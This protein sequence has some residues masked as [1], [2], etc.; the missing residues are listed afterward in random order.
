MD[1][2]QLLILHCWQYPFLYSDG[3]CRG[4]VTD[5]SFQGTIGSEWGKAVHGS[6]GPRPR[7]EG[8][9]RVPEMGVDQ[10][11]ISGSFLSRQRSYK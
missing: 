1:F 11:K 6:T 10:M 2:T 3:S 7:E 9:G 8:P 4:I 5:F